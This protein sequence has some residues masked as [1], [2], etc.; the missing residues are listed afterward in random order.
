[1][2]RTDSYSALPFWIPIFI[3]ATLAMVLIDRVRT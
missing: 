2:L 1:M 3:F